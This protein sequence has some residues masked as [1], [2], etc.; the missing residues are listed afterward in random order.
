MR[1]G[2]RRQRSMTDGARIERPVVAL[3][4]EEL[5]AVLVGQRAGRDGVRAVVAG[6]AVHAAMLF[7]HAIQRLIL[8][9]FAAVWQVS[10]RG[11]FEPRLWILRD[12]LHGAMAGDAGL[13]VGRGQLRH[14]IAQAFGLRAGMTV[15]ATV[16][17]LRHFVRRASR[18]SLWTGW[19]HRRRRARRWHWTSDTRRTSTGRRFINA[20]R[21]PAG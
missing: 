13:R 10:Q 9:V 6:F 19:A 2:A 16:D 1:T 8:I 7:G 17:G 3:Q 12:V 15:V 4:L 20:P 18:A 5:Q 11:S 21:C 14:D